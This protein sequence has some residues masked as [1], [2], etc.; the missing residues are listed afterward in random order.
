MDSST[1]D[2]L[3]FPLVLDKLAGFTQSELGKRLSLDLTP[4]S[5]IE[6]LEAEQQLI[7]EIMPL[8]D[9]GT[10]L[11][12]SGITDLAPYLSKRSLPGYFVTAENFLAI[13]STIDVVCEL[14]AQ[15]RAL[16]N[17][18]MPR[19]F[20][21]TLKL[22]DLKELALKI[23]RAIDENGHIKDSASKKLKKIR[24]SLK[25]KREECRRLLRGYITQEGVEGEEDGEYV[26]IRDDRLVVAIKA[27]RH[28][29]IKGVIHGRSATGL[30]FFI[31]PMEALGINND[32]AELKRDE[33]DEEIEVLRELT[34]AL[35]EMADEITEALRIAALI[36]LVQAKV[37]FLKYISGVVPV[38]SSVAELKMDGSRHPLLLFKELDGGGKVIEVD[39]MLKAGP[40]V[41]IISGANAGG[42][43]VAL[44]SIGL[45]TLMAMSALPVPVREGS[46]FVFYENI[47]TDIGD[48]QDIA[49]DLSTFSAHLKRM[50]EILGESSA[51]T[52]VLIDEIGVGT[53]PTEGGAIALAMLETLI[54]RGV[55]VVVTTHLNFLKAH[56]ATDAG[57]NNASVLFDES[58]GRPLYKI[59]YGAPGSSFGLKAAAKYGVPKEVIERARELTDVKESAFSESLLS[60]EEKKIELEA[61]IEKLKEV[62]RRREVALNRIR[63]DRKKL[64]DKAQ[65]KI[66]LLMEKAQKKI[67]QVFAE[68]K[69]VSRRA[70]TGKVLDGTTITEG[71]A[72]LSKPRRHCE[73]KRLNERGN[74]C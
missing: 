67:D 38:F 42:K 17:E 26:T 41:L 8:M 50:S 44:K 28:A 43:T 55:S 9:T 18:E 65:K 53:D 27:P 64:I 74:S 12:V 70:A 5:S 46:T 35:F 59:G 3:E 13:L 68:T 66:D 48:R 23:R 29:S 32:L 52:I 31:E 57:F 6:E 63:D 56:G 36:D 47:H 54:K 15:A 37:R 39:I 24:T 69:A 51:G 4:L 16:I 40:G 21:L 10:G 19:L 60:F 2:A 11:P 62:N 71:R 33:I 7:K 20:S 30:T 45:L 72:I 1:L 22:P 61:E 58:N 14:R 49:E 34:A 25:K 73:D